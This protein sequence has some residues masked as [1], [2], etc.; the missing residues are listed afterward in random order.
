[1]QPNKKGKQEELDQG[2]SGEPPLV[3]CGLDVVR[4]RRHAQR[5]SEKQGHN[6]VGAEW[7]GIVGCWSLSY[8]SLLVVGPILIRKPCGV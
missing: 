4:R 5:R 6:Q 7:R 8:L 3:G 2:Q 1:V